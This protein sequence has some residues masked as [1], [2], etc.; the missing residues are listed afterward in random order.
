MNE[1][2]ELD[3]VCPIILERMTRGNFECNYVKMFTEAGK[4]ALG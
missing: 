2:I 4:L 1:G 3:S